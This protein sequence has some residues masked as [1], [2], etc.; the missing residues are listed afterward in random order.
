MTHRRDLLRMP[1]AAIAVAAGLTSAREAEAAAPFATAQPSAFRRLR[2]GEIQVT[3]LLDGTVTLPLSTMHTNTTPERVDA[4]LAAAFLRSPVELSVNAYLVNTGD[5]LV[6]IDAGT[7]DLLGPRLGR[8]PEAMRAS[9]YDPE[10]V[11]DVLLTHLHTD[12]SGGLVVGG[13]RAFPNATVHVNRRDADFWLDA[14]NAARASD[15]QRG[16]F[17]EAI[18]SVAPYR[19]AERF[20]TFAD[21][22]APIPGFGSIWRPGHTPGHSSF[23]V[24][25]G[26]ERMV[27]WGDITHGDVV[28]FGAPE[29]GIA[30]FDIDPS[31]AAASRAAA[32]AEAAGRRHWVAGAH[33]AFPGIGHVRRGSSGY[34]WVQMN[35]SAEG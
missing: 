5:R 8:L 22:A 30:P 35:F 9:G 25:G 31:A 3:A 12:H 23:V 16:L 24:E 20:R 18:S 4:A 34:D 27:F 28:Q 19:D 21:G 6:L 26:G 15:A 32:F 29:V 33:I 1:A 17:H 2:L 14:A 13:R 10:Q 11:D 7:A